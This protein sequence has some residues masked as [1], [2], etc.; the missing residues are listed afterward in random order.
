M[1]GEG[2]ADPEA[3]TPGE[4]AVPDVSKPHSCRSL[5]SSR[6]QRAHPSRE[7]LSGPRPSGPGWGRPRKRAGSRRGSHSPRRVPLPASSVSAARCFLKYRCNLDLCLIPF[8]CI[9]HCVMFSQVRPRVSLES[10]L[11]SWLAWQTYLVR[12]PRVRPS[13]APATTAGPTPRQC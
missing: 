6:Q 4:L 2:L 7:P 10:R 8:N 12:R 13:P 9:L 3:F 5:P 11:R 1:A